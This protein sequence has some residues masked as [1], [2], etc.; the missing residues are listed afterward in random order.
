MEQEISTDEIRQALREYLAGHDSLADV[1][2]VAEASQPTAGQPTAG[3]PT[4]GQPTAGPPTPAPV[5]A[6]PPPF[7]PD[8]WRGM[9]R[10]LGAGGLAVPVEYG[11]LGLGLR[12]VTGALFEAGCVLYPGPLRSTIAAAVALSAAA[13]EADVGPVG[14][15]RPVATALAAIASG[16]ATAALAVPAG[17][18]AGGC[19]VIADGPLLRGTA[20]AVP[21]G[22]SADLLV[23]AAVAAGRPALILV[24]PADLATAPRV[25]LT[26]TDFSC[27]YADI[28]LDAVPGAVL[29][30]DPRT[31]SRVLDLAQVLTAAEQV[32]TAAGALSRTLEYL[33]VREQYGRPIGAYQ[34]VQ[35]RCA[36]LA[37]HIEAASALVELAA[38]AADS[39]DG[40]LL[41]RVGLLA[42]AAASEVSVAAADA[43]VHLHGGIGF[44]WEH[45]AHLFFRR[46]RTT[47]SWFGTVPQLRA[48][49]ARRDCF[50]LITQWAGTEA[51][52][53]AKPQI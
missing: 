12:A 9:A 6:G 4:A 44:T 14:P 16:A 52:D 23:A 53:G 32:G 10:D 33:K 51:L 21:H 7:D 18:V 46:A 17:D 50:A 38:A 43:M 20:R 30:A 41:A 25:I 47:A 22:A 34:A 39:G 19:G 31:V 15:G 48:E 26:G 35:H 49:A 3:Q 11:G 45:E 24:S 5:P 13:R 1:R 36:D 40:E 28:V 42:R 29:S 8:V 27:G 37:V 2:A